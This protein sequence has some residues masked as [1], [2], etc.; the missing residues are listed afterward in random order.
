MRPSRLLAAV[1]AVALAVPL[2]TT[3]ACGPAKDCHVDGECMLTCKTDPQHSDAECRNE[4]TECDAG[5][6]DEET[7]DDT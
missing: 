7:A 4:C 5:P 6:Q 1:A 3:A 2:F